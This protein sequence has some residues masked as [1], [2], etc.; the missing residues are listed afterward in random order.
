MILEFESEKKSKGPFGI[1]TE[2]EEYEQRGISPVE[3][4]RCSRGS[5]V[6]YD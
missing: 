3:K 4:D 2:K 5:G 6:V 1:S